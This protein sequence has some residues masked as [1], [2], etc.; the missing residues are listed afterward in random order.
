[1]K[2]R[3]AAL[4]LLAV[5]AQAAGAWRPAGWVYMGHPWAYDSATG[6]WMW[7]N[8]DTQYIRNMTAGA[9]NLLPDSGIATGWVFYQWPFA[10]AQ[11][12]N[13]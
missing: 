5:L 9:W 2:K 12:N 8:P 11:A 3:I 7:F 6:Q 10:Y 13:G 4:G 1:M